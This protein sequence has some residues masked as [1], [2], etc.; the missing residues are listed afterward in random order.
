MLLIIVYL[1]SFGLFCYD[2]IKKDHDLALFMLGATVYS[3][4]IA[5]S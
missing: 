3:Y 1:I 5:H 2:C 4:I